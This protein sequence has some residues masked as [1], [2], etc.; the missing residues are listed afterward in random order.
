[1]EKNVEFS[2]YWSTGKIDES[3]D[4]EGNSYKHVY[5]YSNTLGYDSSVTLSDVTETKYLYCR[6]SAYLSD[7]NIWLSDYEEIF[8]VVNPETV[9]YGKYTTPSDSEFIQGASFAGQGDYFYDFT[10]LKLNAEQTEYIAGDGEAVTLDANPVT[11]DDSRFAESIRYK[12]YM[13]EGNSGYTLI[14]GANESTYEVPEEVL[15]SASEYR[16][17]CKATDRTGSSAYCYFQVHTA[18]RIQV[19]EQVKCIKTTDKYE[20]LYFLFTPEKNGPYFPVVR[21]CFVIP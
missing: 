7:S 8:F 11:N 20:R 18:E 6:V 5:N 3:T 2:Y 9:Y 21:S 1:V 13:S 17:E 14:E 4:S 19:N 15:A 12:W 10:G 16:F